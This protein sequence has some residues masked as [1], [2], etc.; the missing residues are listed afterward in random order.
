MIIREAKH[1]DW[2]LIWP[3]FREIVLEGQTYAY[4]PEI[5][6]GDAEKIWLADP[7]ATF[8]AEDGGRILGTYY[9]KSNQAG[10]G[11]HVCNCGYMVSPKARGKG[12]ASKLCEH[13]QSVALNLGY[14]AM[15]FNFVV[16]SNTG[17]VRLWK[18]LGFEIVGTLPKAF[19]HPGQ[20][21][22]DA[23]V[24]YKWLKS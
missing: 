9:L 14:D 11:G 21:Y 4:D 23:F 19:K 18:K 6:K 8:V 17:D 5:T 10:P 20:A 13:S 24:M 1:D 15:Q 12:V 3:I 16:A 2:N 7:R 22:G